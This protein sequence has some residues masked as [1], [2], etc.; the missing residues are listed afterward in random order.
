M[1]MSCSWKWESPLQSKSRTRERSCWRPLEAAMVISAPTRACQ[2]EPTCFRLVFP[3]GCCR[4]PAAHTS[5]V[6]SVNNPSSWRRR[7]QPSGLHASRG[8]HYM[9]SMWTKHGDMSLDCEITTQV[10]VRLQQSLYVCRHV[11]KQQQ[12][13]THLLSTFQLNKVTQSKLNSWTC[14]WPRVWWRWAG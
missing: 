1:M 11:T 4:S 13:N 3:W 10:W 9:R 12:T 2:I 8:K 7:R 14:N 6:D 5:D